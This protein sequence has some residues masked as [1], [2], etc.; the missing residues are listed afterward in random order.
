LCV[1]I[2]DRLVADKLRRGGLELGDIKEQV[3]CS[4]EVDE[5]V[6]VEDVGVCLDKGLFVDDRAHEPASMY[7]G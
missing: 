2:G 7:L 4:S 3:D 6:E 5:E 1:T